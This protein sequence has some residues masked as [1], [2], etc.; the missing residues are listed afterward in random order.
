MPTERNFY[1]RK[2][3]EMYIE[4]P[5]L[6]TIS[7][8]EYRSLLKENTGYQQRVEYLENKLLEERKKHYES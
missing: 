2:D 3:G 6:V 1:I 5:L 4:E 7:L 8:E